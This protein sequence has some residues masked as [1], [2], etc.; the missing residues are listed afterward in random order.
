MDDA[1][2]TTLPMTLAAAV[3]GAALGL[4]YFRGLWWTLRLAMASPRPAVW[5]GCSLLLRLAGAAGGFVVV[6]AGDWARLL[7]CLLGF[8]VARGLILRAT[9]QG[10]T[11]HA[12]RA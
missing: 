4:F 9:A 12:P 5:V 10:S 11:R 8:W 7:S 1:I 6:G 3:A 2:T